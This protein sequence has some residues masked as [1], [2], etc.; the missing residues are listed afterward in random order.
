[1]VVCFKFIIQKL[2]VYPNIDVHGMSK[3]IMEYEKCDAMHFFVH[4]KLI[5]DTL[6]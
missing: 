2:K 4:F 6:L 1:M 5:I 3:K